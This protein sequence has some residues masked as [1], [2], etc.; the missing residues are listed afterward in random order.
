MSK[1]AYY[2][3]HDANARHDPKMLIIQARF[4]EA[5]YARYFKIIEM[6]R[7]AQDYK[8]KNDDILY[9]IIG[10]D[11]GIPPDEAKRFIDSCI[12]IGLFELNEYLYSNS[13]LNRMETKERLSTKRAESISRRWYKDDTNHDTNSNTK[14]IQN[15][16]KTDTVKESKGKERKEKEIK[17][18]I[19]YISSGGVSEADLV[20]AISGPTN[21]KPCPLWVKK[22]CTAAS[23]RCEVRGASHISG[24]CYLP[25]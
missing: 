24:D 13:L 9:A 11:L 22:K 7:E 12:E 3:S 4:K 18:N 14:P 2:F 25:A 21:R 6:M 15:G 1:D 16:Y 17:E 5:G 23:G 19:D 8:L 20:K 10:L